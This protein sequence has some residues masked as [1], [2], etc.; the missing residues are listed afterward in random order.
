MRTI[1]CRFQGMKG[2][3][4]TAM[5]EPGSGWE[6]A[7]ALG[8]VSQLIEKPTHR[9]YPLIRTIVSKVRAVT[10]LLRLG[11]ITLTHGDAR[12]ENF[13]YSSREGEHEA[14]ICD[15]QMVMISNPMRF[16]VPSQSRRSLS[17]LAFSHPPLN[18]DPHPQR[19]CKL[20]DK[21]P[22]HRESSKLERRARCGVPR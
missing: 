12:A 6:Q 5:S 21:L 10:A 8:R 13:F 2:E 4:W 16:V 20:C 9:I 14:A 17:Y 15:F 7:E 19:L 3:S 1:C 18:L 22:R 11:P